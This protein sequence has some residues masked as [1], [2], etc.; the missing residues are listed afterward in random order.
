M[1]NA[2]APKATTSATSD[3]GGAASLLSDLRSS[4]GTGE[5]GAAPKP[6]KA[7]HS[8]YLLL[9]VLVA[10]SA[11]VLYGMRRYG[12]NSGIVYDK[13]V[14]VQY[15]SAGKSGA[16][17]AEAAK[18][19]QELERSGAPVEVPKEA[20]DRN[21]FVLTT[22]ATEV[23][24]PTDNTDAKMTELARKQAEAARKA[25]EEHMQAISNALAALELKAVLSGRVPVARI[26]DRSYRVGDTVDELFKVSAIADRSVT[27]ECEGKQ[28]TIEIA[29]EGKDGRR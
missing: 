26:G 16:S 11:G 21:P 28:Y 19:L 23:A 8:S 27:L 6:P 5:L 22:A 4:A 17:A 29:I 25:R 10:V 1:S 24:V 9:V 2:T 15:T 20:A 14:E 3:K 12:M 7:R 13:A 18:M